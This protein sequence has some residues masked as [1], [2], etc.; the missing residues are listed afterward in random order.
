MAATLAGRATSQPDQG[1]V[2]LKIADSTKKIVPASSVDLILTSPPYCT[3]IDYSAATRIE[4]A[5][6]HPLLKLRMED[7]GRSMIGSTRVPDRE[8]AIQSGWGETCGR[9][10]AELKAHRSKASDGYYLKTH[11]D[12]FDKMASSLGNITAA[13]KPKG[14]AILVVQDSFYKEIHNDLP[15]ITVEMAVDAG[16]RLRRR[17]DFHLKRSMAGMNPHSRTYKRPPGALEAVLCFAKD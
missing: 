9:F 5:L 12:Y 4:L 6:L 17:N 15:G 8:I 13:L 7:L 11:L 10:V 16:L 2:A 3:R 1:A 14:A